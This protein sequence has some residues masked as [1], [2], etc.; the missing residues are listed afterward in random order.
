MSPLHSATP[1][2]LPSEASSRQIWFPRAD[3][4]PEHSGTILS[5]ACLDES[6]PVLPKR[7]RVIRFE[8]SLPPKPSA[9]RFAVFSEDTEAGGSG[10]TVRP[11]PH[12][13]ALRSPR[14]LPD[15]WRG[16]CHQPRA[17]ARTAGVH[18]SH[19]STT[20]AQTPGLRQA[21]VWAV[22]GPGASTGG[23]PPGPRAV[24]TLP[25][26][27]GGTSSTGVGGEAPEV[28][29]DATAMAWAPLGLPQEVSRPPAWGGVFP[30]DPE[31]MRGS[32][33]PSCYPSA[34]ARTPV[35]PGP[36]WALATPTT[37]A[38]TQA[39]GYHS[40]GN[41]AVRAAVSSIL[42]RGEGFPQGHSVCD[43]TSRAQ[44]RGL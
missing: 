42:Q 44:N 27:G 31:G 14:C 43:S 7:E 1:F 33:V 38:P 36:S 18:G 21:R 32:A 13:R 29:A 4:S 6:T 9:P 25:A 11:S 16:A 12:A 19:R 39:W 2:F 10:R 34:P 23:W 35:I 3:M 20:Q 37:G 5:I 28:P 40:S 17:A 30:R 15:A 41:P 26:Q 8:Q 22:G 24:A